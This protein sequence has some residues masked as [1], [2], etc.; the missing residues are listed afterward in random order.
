M[1]EILRIWQLDVECSYSFWLDGSFTL[2]LFPQDS[3]YELRLLSCR[4]RLVS[5]PSDSVVIS[6]EGEAD[7]EM[8]ILT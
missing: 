1:C 6:T 4:D 5:V 7:S 3:N 8:C 2:H